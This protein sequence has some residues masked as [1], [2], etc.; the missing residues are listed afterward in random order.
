MKQR[1]YLLIYSDS[2]GE[3][4]EVK[5][6]LDKQAE[7]SHWRFDMPNTFYL[8]SDR[9][10]QELYEVVQRFNEKRG[11]FL[12]SEIGS[13]KQG[14]LPAKTWHLLNQKTYG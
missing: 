12:I 14:W 2:M 5:G 13:N 3:R 4:E 1:A 9:S 6:F 10:A 7:I 8:V 11:R